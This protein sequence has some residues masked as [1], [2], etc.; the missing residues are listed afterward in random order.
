MLLQA[1]NK[2]F[3]NLTPTEIKAI[4]A[5]ASK[6]SRSKQDAE[7]KLKAAGFCSFTVTEG[8]KSITS[9]SCHI[10]ANGPDGAIYNSMR[11]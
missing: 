2:T 9:F 10:F 5:D 1:D 7:A 3:S 6:K 4:I 11:C 8:F